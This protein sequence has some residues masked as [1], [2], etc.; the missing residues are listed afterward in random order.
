MVPLTFIFLGPSGCGK[1]TQAK[2]LID[3]LKKTDSDKRSFLYLEAGA[4]FRKFIE[5]N[6]HASLLSK[7]VYE[8]GN[9]QPEFLAIWNWSSSFIDM[10]RG[11]EHL[12]VDGTPRRLNE[13]K[14]FVEA[15]NFFKRNRPIVISIDV[16]REFSER[17]LLSRGRLDDSKDDI[18]KRL[19]WFETEVKPALVYL[20]LHSPFLVIDIDGEQPI[21]KVH[22]DVIA[23]IQ[24][25]GI[26]S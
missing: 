2:L 11:G 25:E 5:E 10:L 13:A 9:I 18:R 23:K 21:E 1:G 4:R 14:I 16:S 6:S 26:F 8:S 15:M 20:K 22:K 7:E 19:D 24:K 3:H 12:I 17:L